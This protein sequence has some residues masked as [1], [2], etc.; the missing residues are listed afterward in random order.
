MKWESAAPHDP[1]TMPQMI[2]KTPPNVNHKPA[3]R[4]G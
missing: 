1:R 4:G 3:D 2:E